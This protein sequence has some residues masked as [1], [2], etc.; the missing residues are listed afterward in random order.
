VQNFKSEAEESAS[1]FSLLNGNIRF[2]LPDFV[3][4][5]A[6]RKTFSPQRESSDISLAEYTSRGLNQGKR[7]M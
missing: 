4:M 7:G 2:Q 3:C 6:D 1:L 5:Q